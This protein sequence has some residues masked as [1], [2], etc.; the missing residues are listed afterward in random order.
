MVGDGNE[1][2]VHRVLVNVVEAREVRRLDGEACFPIVEPNTA[3]WCTV[4]LVDPGSS[5]GMEITK[6]HGQVFRGGYGGW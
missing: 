5:L 2:M 4:E 1:A 3:L 6:H